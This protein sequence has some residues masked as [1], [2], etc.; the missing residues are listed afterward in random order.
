MASAA[1]SNFAL[2]SSGAKIDRTKDGPV[3]N[4]ISDF[5]DWAAL[6]L[7]MVEAMINVFGPLKKPGGTATI[8][9]VLS[10]TVWD[11]PACTAVL[12][13]NRRAHRTH[14]RK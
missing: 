10:V 11:I 3:A 5:P 9:A 6:S 4:T 12:D 7:I 2:G 8:I 1:A 14:Q 13:D